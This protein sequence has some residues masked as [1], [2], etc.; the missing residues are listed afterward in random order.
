MDTV[1]NRLVG[2]I[3]FVILAPCELNR[4]VLAALT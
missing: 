4:N 3:Y 1:Q 2:F